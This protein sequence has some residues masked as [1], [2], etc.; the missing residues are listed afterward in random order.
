[1]KSLEITIL[2]LLHAFAPLALSREQLQTILSSRGYAVNWA[3][4]RLI[5]QKLIFRQQILPISILATRTRYRL[6]NF[7][8]SDDLSWDRGYN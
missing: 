7:P 3:D 2:S 8:D 5:L 1:M 4:L 6:C